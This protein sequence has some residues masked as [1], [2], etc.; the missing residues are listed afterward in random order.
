M[1]LNYRSVM[2]IEFVNYSYKLFD[3]SKYANILPILS[4]ASH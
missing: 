3:Y 1:I 4:S 2:R